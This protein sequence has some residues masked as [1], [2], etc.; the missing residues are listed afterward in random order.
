[1]LVKAENFDYVI[2]PDE[3][4]EPCLKIVDGRLR[5]P[6][7]VLAI[8]DLGTGVSGNG[9]QVEAEGGRVCISVV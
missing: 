1:M 5:V 9:E 6:C 4:G 2:V 8:V 3:N 7:P